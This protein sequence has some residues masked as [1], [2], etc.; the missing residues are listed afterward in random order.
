MT[1]KHQINLNFEL[2]I[3]NDGRKYIFAV[4]FKL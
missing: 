2:G 4:L 3:E 1:K